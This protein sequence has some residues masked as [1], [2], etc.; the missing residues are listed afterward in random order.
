MQNHSIIKIKFNN[1]TIAEKIKEEGLWMF[2]CNYRIIEY[3]KTNTVQQC[4]KCFD[5]SHI[6]I[7]C[8]NDQVCSEC[9]SKEHTWDK[10]T[11]I[12]KKCTQCQG[13][14]RTFWAGCP[15][16]KAALEKKEE[17]ETRKNEEKEHSTYANIIKFNSQ[18]TTEA[19]KTIVQ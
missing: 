9:S 11:S 14:H 10:C 6:K 13:Q 15:I 16:R 3:E 17:I 4:M 19:T 18:Q 2:G 7:N 1:L 5:Y 12:I 8:T